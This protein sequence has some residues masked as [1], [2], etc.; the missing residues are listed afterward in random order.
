MA[1]TKRKR[2]GGERLRWNPKTKQPEKRVRLCGKKVLFRMPSCSTPEQATERETIL[3]R[4]ADQ[5]TARCIPFLLARQTLR[6]VAVADSQLTLDDACVLCADVLGGDRLRAD[7]TCPTFDTVFHYWQSN[8]LARDYPDLKRADGKTIKLR[9]PSTVEAAERH[10]VNHVKPIVGHLPVD[11]I[12]LTLADKIKASV[13]RVNMTEAESR[14]Q[15]LQAFKQCMDLCASLGYIAVS[16]LP[17]GWLP[18]RPAPNDRRKLQFIYPSEEALLAAGYSPEQ[19]QLIRAG[20][21]VTQLR[22]VVEFE[23]RFLWAFTVRLARRKTEV[24]LLELGQITWRKD[25]RAF[26]RVRGDQT[27]G[28]K[29]YTVPLNEAHTRA[30]RFYIALC[31]SGAAPTDRIFVTPEGQPINPRTINLPEKLRSHLWAV[32]VRRPELHQ[33]I[34]R[35]ATSKGSRQFVMHDLRASNV[36]VQDALGVADNAIR[37]VTNHEHAETVHLYKRQVDQAA[38]LGES[39]FVALDQALP[40]FCAPGTFALPELLDDS[41]PTADDLPEWLQAAAHRPRVAL[42]AEAAPSV[43][44]TRALPADVPTAPAAAAVDQ[45]AATPRRTGQRMA[46]DSRKPRE[47]GGAHSTIVEPCGPS[48]PLGTIESAIVPSVVAVPCPPISDP[49]G[50]TMAALRAQIA[51]LQA[52]VAGVAAQLQAQPPARRRKRSA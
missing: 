21:D 10:Y 25:K 6:R 33:T 22:P 2:G 15:A 37:K 49:S 7:S 11:A 40:E 14:R 29:E 30:L 4:L 23:W 28:G 19:Q 39:D 17:K 12:T 52:V 18:S 27:K 51:A 31:R 26:I 1:I 36:T 35:S 5:F 13:G 50:Q 20:A 16:P 3:I 9:G 48:E 45:V 32:G 34:K 41:A 42:P 47:T 43:T 24:T 38:M 8:Q 46:T 44:P